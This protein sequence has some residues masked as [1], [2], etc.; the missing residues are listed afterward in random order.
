MSDRKSKEWTHHYWAAAWLDLLGQSAAFKRTDFVPTS[1]DDPRVGAFRQAVGESIGAIRDVRKTLDNFRAQIDDK[2]TPPESSDPAKKEFIRRSRLSSVRVFRISDGMLLACPLK[3]EGDEFPTT[4]VHEIVMTCLSMLP[5]QLSKKRPIRGGIEVGT[6]A[7][8]DGEFFGAAMVKAYEI[9]RDC[10]EYPRVV[11][12][13]GMMSFLQAARA[14]PGDN[15]YLA[16][17]RATAEKV[18]SV[19][20]KDTDGKWVLDYLGQGVRAMNIHL[21]PFVPEMRAFVDGERNKFRAAN[22]QKLFGRYS[23]L[24]QFIDSR[25]PPK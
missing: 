7:E 13:Q 6:G 9:E 10:A 4:S 18:L 5:I 3:P 14:E 16:Y 24:L 2:R 15:P 23:Q 1:D 19:I 25:I 22:N 21:D 20:D 11:V 17:Q 12:G 8:I